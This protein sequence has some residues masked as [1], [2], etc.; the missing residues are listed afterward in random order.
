MSV[1]C[2]GEIRKAP[3]WMNRGNRGSARN[4]RTEEKK[5]TWP[6]LM[7]LVLV[8]LLAGATAVSC[9]GGATGQQGGQDTAKNGGPEVAS[10]GTAVDLDDPYLGDVGAPV[11]LIEYADFQ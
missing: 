5:P 6:L 8:T 3:S 11:V 10:Q 1:P 9:G 2:P 4:G 7:R